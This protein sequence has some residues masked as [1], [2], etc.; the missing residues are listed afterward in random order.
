[1][2]PS[3]TKSVGKSVTSKVAKSVASKSARSK[4]A[5]KRKMRR[6]RAEARVEHTMRKIPRHLRDRH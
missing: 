4:A 1:M 2:A 5:R 3:S 6:V